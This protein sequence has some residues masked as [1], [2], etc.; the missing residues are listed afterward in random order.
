M[1]KMERNDYILQE[2]NECKLVVRQFRV[3]AFHVKANK[4]IYSGLGDKMKFSISPLN[5]SS[6]LSGVFVYDLN[7]RFKK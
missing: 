2:E 7:K 6:G 4:K 1:P 3:L 5:K